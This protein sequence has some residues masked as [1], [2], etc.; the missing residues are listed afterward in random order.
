MLEIFLPTRTYVQAFEERHGQSDASSLRMIIKHQ[1]YCLSPSNEYLLTPPSMIQNGLNWISNVGNNISSFI[2]SSLH[3]SNSNNNNNATINSRRGGRM[4][5]N[6]YA[7]LA[8][9]DND[10]DDE[11]GKSVAET[12]LFEENNDTLRDKKDDESIG[13]VESKV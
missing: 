3:Q 1:R 9:L 6:G 13:V 12:T 11:D 2:T 10:D 7:A 8:T 4:N 5:R